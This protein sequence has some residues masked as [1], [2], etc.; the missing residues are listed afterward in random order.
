M[1]DKYFMPSKFPVDKKYYVCDFIEEIIKEELDY[2]YYKLSTKN[3]INYVKRA[4]RY[5]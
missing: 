4:I 5:C 3:D 1:D 2:I